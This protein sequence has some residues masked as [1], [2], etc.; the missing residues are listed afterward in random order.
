MILKAHGKINL[1]LDITGKRKDG[2][3]DIATLMQS[4]ELCDEIE[5]T[6]NDKGTILVTSDSKALPDGEE[7]IAYRACR[8]MKEA[9][10]LNDGFQISIRK[11]IPLA[12][13]MAGGSADAAAVIRAVNSLCQLNLSE[14]QLMEIGVTLGADIPFCIQEKPAFAT[15][16]GE[17][18]TPVKGLSKDIFIILVNPKVAVSTKVIYEAIDTA[19]QYG[20]VDNKALISA[21]KDGDIN[22]AKEY[23]VNIME[24]VTSAHCK[25]VPEIIKKLNSMGAIHAMMTGSGATCFGLFEKKPDEA[26]FKKSFPDFYVCLTKPYEPEN[27]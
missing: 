10:A 15:G 14:K 5:I 23:M 3:H 8:K 27:R 7:N 21:L 24:P 16:I 22:R 13:G 4:V 9:F 18:L 6:K 12:G 19:A 26:S 2:Y 25:E 1:S 20:S 17:I 11:R